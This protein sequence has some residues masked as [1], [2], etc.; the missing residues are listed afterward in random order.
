MTDCKERYRELIHARDVV[1][2]E[3]LA[4]LQKMSERARIERY[5]EIKGNE[6]SFLFEFTADCPDF[7]TDAEQ[8]RVRS[9]FRLARLLVA[10][11]FYDDGAVPK[12]LDEDFVEAELQAVVDFDRYK[13][14][15]AL[16]EDQIQRRIRRMEGEVYELVRDYH[17]TQLSDMDA[18]LENPDVQR[19][20]MERLVERYE[21]RFEKV[22]QGFY[23]FVET[24]G[25]EHMVET[26]ERAVLAVAGAERERELVRTEL[27]EAL[28]GAAEDLEETGRDQR[29]LE[30]RL[31]RLQGRLGGGA[32]PEEL[33]TELEAIREAFQGIDSGGAFGE[34]IDATEGMIGRL[35]SKIDELEAVRDEASRNAPDSS[36]E[37][38]TTVVDE[39]LEKLREER[40]AVQRELEGLRRERERVE[41]SRE[42]L[43]ERQAELEE[44]VERTTDDLADQK[45]ELEDRVE[46]VKSSLDPETL[47]GDV[48]TATMARLYEL[49]YM[50]RFDTS[51]AEV[52][53]IRTP[54]GDFD[55]P[56]GYWKGRSEHYTDRVQPYDGAFDDDS[57]ARP[58]GRGARYEI[59]ASRYLGLS[60][61]LEMVVEAMVHVDDDAFAANGFDAAPAGLDDLLAIVDEPIR[62]AD[63]GD[64]HH[65]LA[66]A[67]PTGWTDRAVGQLE[68]DDLARSRLSANVSVVL[69]D[70]ESGDVTYDPT[71]EVADENA[72]LF[73]FEVDAERV[74]ECR[75]TI[76]SEYLG[77]PGEDSVLVETLVEEHGFSARTANGAF[78]ELERDG[79]GEQLYI[80]DLGMAL[81][82]D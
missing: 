13:S 1:L 28:T 18:L 77:V 66:I 25:L 32:D 49:D 65:L 44:T 42:R 45:A 16:S 64:Y 26:V 67:S 69:V 29:E 40:E 34:R 23:T 50:G 6:E 78:D 60:R 24:H 10:A 51:M 70:L 21:D 61:D 75:S 54:S 48:V 33:R 52:E 2:D 11:S 41:R 39:E 47:G 56:E 3:D 55:V 82:F 37:E 20:V 71:D 30:L 59:T 73:G 22:R 15:D 27:D 58:A 68:D 62:D 4:A 79:V 7:F 63:A 31:K 12:P 76:E 17:S 74:R 81:V 38:T 53:T 36:R 43:E 35:E 19:D 5:N 14:F 72:H 57:H 46:S 80:E 8:D 9:E